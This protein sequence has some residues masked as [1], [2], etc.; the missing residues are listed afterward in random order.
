MM[1]FT[2]KPK[3]EKCGNDGLKKETPALTYHISCWYHGRHQKDCSCAVLAYPETIE[4]R[5]IKSLCEEHLLMTCGRCYHRWLMRPD[6]DSEIGV[7]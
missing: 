3:C 1:P 6:E 5:E 2:D 7:F 4:G